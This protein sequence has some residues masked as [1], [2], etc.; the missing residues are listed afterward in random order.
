MI[1]NLITQFVVGFIALSCIIGLGI[2][3]YS[4]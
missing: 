1:L 2:V 4:I 3:I